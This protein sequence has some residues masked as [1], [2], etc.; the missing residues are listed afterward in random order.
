MLS[1]GKGGVDNDQDRTVAPGMGIA[2]ATLPGGGPPLVLVV[3]DEPDVRSFLE[4]VLQL[5]G[6][7]VEPLV[8]GAGLLDQAVR[9][10][11]ALI[12]LDVMMPGLDGLA[13]V[14][15][16]RADGRTSHI[17]IILLT[18][19][20]QV[21]DTIE[22]LEVGAD[23]YVTKP[24]DPGELVARVRATLRRANQMRTMSPLTGLPG[25]ARIEQELVR[26]LR[27]DA[28]LAL[29]YADLNEFKAVNDYYG[30]LHGDRVIRGLAA[31]VTGAAA[32]AGDRDTFVG[33]VGGD[34]FVVIH[35]SGGV[36]TIARR[37][38][39]QFD[40]LVPD[41]YE[42]R[43][44][45]RGYIEV[46]DRRGVPTRYP[47]VTVSIGIATTRR[48]RFQH[49]AELMHAATEVKRYAKQQ[50]PEGRSNWEIDRRLESPDG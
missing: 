44:W 15:Y 32:D 14:R 38:C 45:E 27:D 6:F 29:L 9:R 48:R 50:R 41:F 43:D 46:E 33:H 4:I 24:F 36:R 18:A 25:N 28:P 10:Q 47:P 2:D 37:I 23:D 21:E 12:L 7:E 49:P 40:S 16:L 26:R 42:P 13:S 11:P 31:A 3:D 1:A 35:Q 19:R 5:A 22:G 34:D 17:P 39:E 8:D 20:S 30:P